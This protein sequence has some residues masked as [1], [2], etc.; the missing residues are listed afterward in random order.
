MTYK[1]LTATIVST[2]IAFPIIAFAHPGNLDKYGCHTCMTN[3]PFYGLK[4]SEYHCHKNKDWSK[5]YTPAQV[6]AP[7]KKSVASKSSSSKATKITSSKSIK[8]TKK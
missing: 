4:K 7:E 1:I 2:A 8:S 5:N 3:C 6:N